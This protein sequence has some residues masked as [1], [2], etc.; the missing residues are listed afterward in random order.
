M[1]ISLEPTGQSALRPDSSN[2]GPPQVAL[3]R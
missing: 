1:M 3:P 2:G